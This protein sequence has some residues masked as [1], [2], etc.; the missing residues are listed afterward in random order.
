MSTYLNDFD[1]MGEDL[2]KEGMAII[3][4][5]V[6]SYNGVIIAKM[7]EDMAVELVLSLWQTC[8]S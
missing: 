1:G 5:S 2:R 8:M 6:G 7:E 3:K 4:K